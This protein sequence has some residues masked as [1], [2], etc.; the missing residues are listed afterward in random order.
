MPESNAR[1]TSLAQIL[2]HR[3]GPGVYLKLLVDIMAMLA[4]RFDVHAQNVCDFLVWEALG[5]QFQNF[6]LTRRQGLLLP[7]MNR[8]M[9]EVLHNLAGDETVQRRTA[10]R[11]IAD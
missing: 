1:V 6:A 3:L 9:V 2:Y 11:R 5:K 8:L 4:N 7:G 10:S